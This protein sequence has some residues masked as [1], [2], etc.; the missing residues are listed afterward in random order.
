MS[1][2]LKIVVNVG[3]GISISTELDQYDGTFLIEIE[4]LFHFCLLRIKAGSRLN[5]WECLLTS[6]SVT[7]VHESKCNRS[8]LNVLR[9]SVGL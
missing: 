4:L 9:N 5:E 1:G 7:Y 6:F 3:V 8:G 2:S